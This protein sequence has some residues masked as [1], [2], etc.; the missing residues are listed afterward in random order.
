MQLY[1][2]LRAANK[3]PAEPAVAFLYFAISLFGNRFNLSLA[4]CHFSSAPLLANC[5][6]LNSVNI[7][8]FLP[9]S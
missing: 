1:Q 4:L 8:I 5:K 3:P 9:L 2:P 7:A 6:I